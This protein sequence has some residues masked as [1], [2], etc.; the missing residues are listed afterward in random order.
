MVGV[1]HD[2]LRMNAS[3]VLAG[4]DLQHR[5]VVDGRSDRVRA[6]LRSTQ[7]DTKDVRSKLVRLLIIFICVK[8]ATH[9][10]P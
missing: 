4:L 3:L 5:E 1:L 10:V 7:R 9:L 8:S 6:L 2:R